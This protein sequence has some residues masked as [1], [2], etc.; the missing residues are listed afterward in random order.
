[1]GLW[2]QRE[3][4]IWIKNNIERF[5]GDPQRIT[6]WGQS[7]GG[8]STS[9]HSLSKH[10]RGLFQQIIIHSGSPYTKWSTNEKVVEMSKNL[11]MTLN[12]PVDDSDKLKECMKDL[13]VEDIMEASSEFVSFFSVLLVFILASCPRRLSLF[14]LQSTI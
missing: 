6:L 7:A 1:M 4:L 9:M 3:A 14:K 10:S 12:C 11:A 2:D 8:A 5:G 13:D